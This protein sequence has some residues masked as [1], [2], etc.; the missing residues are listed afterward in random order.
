MEIDKNLITFGKYNS[1]SIDDVLKDRS[2]CKWLLQ[3]EF[4]KN[5][6]EYLYNRVKEFDPKIFFFSPIELEGSFIDTYK[7][8]NLTP[9]DKLQISLTENELICYKYYLNMIYNF[10][11]KIKD[12]IE[13]SK[14]NPYDIK[15]PVN[16]L[17]NFEKETKLSRDEFKKF[18]NCYELNNLPYIIKDIKEQAGI[19]YHGADI[20]NIVKERS[21]KQEAFWEKILKEKYG[22]DIGS[23]Y[24]Y[25]NS[26]F[27]FINISK[28]ILYECKLNLKD[29]NIKQYD[30]YVKATKGTYEM[31]YLISDDCILN[32][33]KQVIYTKNVEKYKTEIV[34]LCSSNIAIEFVN[35]LLEC[36]FIETESIIEIFNEKFD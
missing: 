36:M 1:K 27:D 18:I 23:Q 32:I 14:P 24:K 19:S 8:F 6:Y 16:W 21:L 31:I 25:D 15:A 12:N 35:T 30:K 26:V 28:K 4:F 20:Y 3:Q 33:T 10:K 2:Y 11:Q 5:N 9:I 13:Q 7:Y 29:F 17:N 22:E 34:K